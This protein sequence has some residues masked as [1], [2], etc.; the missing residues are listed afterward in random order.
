MNQME[1]GKLPNDVLN[2][3]ILGK[4][5]NRRSE[6]L[7]R[8]SIGEDCSAVDFGREICIISTDPITGTENQI[9]TIGVNVALND[10]ASSGAEPVGIT[11]TLLIPPDASM[12]D[13]ENVINQ[14]VSEA[15]KLN[16]DIIGGHT[17]V[18]DAVSRFVLSITAIGKTINKNVVTTSGAKP[19]D[20]LILTKYA[21]LEG[22][23]IL[24]YDYEE[25]LAEK[26]GKELVDNAKRLINNISVIKEGIISAKFGAHAMH[27]VT[28][29]GVLGAVW[30][31]CHASCCGAVIFK[32]SI[33]V[34]RETKLICDYFNIDPLR[35]IS[36]GCM[37]IACEDG[38]QMVRELSENGIK[39]GII[40]KITADKSI[41]LSTNTENINISPPKSDELYKVSKSK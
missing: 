1:I 41:L 14:L 35:L 6:V 18:T 22:T 15:S 36:S 29:G 38:E 33:P 24:A 9:G 32:D 2:S 23:S 4:L 11:V 37:L 30:E 34:L 20:D 16:V 10:L 17:E 25:E 13:V 31:M 5:Q 39:A 7:L 19:G 40:G 8:P 26:F 12:S 3:L 27:D 28:E 21:G